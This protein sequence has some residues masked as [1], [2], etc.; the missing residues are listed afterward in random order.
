MVNYHQSLVFDRPYLTCYDHCG[1]WLFQEIFY[2]YFQKM[3]F[4]TGVIRN[5]AIFTGK[6]LCWSLFLIIFQPGPKRELN[7]GDFC[8][9]SKFLRTVS[10]KEHLPWLLLSV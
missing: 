4:K 7:S 3:F 9:N 6:D 8:E 2:Y 10:F 1:Q 5:F